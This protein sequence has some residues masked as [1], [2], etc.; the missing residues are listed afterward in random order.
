MDPLGPPVYLRCSVCKEERAIPT[1]IEIV[2][3]TKMIKGF[4]IFHGECEKKYKG[5]EE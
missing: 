3:F 1:P 2:R 5:G 4:R